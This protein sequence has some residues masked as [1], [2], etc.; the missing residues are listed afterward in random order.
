MLDKNLS[1]NVLLIGIKK[2]TDNREDQ[3]CIVPED[4]GY[5]LSRFENIIAQAQELQ[6]T[7]EERFLYFPEQWKI[8]CLREALEL[9][10]RQDDEQRNLISFCSLPV[11]VNE[12]F[13]SVVLQIKRDIYSSYYHLTVDKYIDEK[14]A[15]SLIDAT[16][17]ECLEIYTQALNK[18]NPGIGCEISAPPIYEIIRAAGRRLMY[19]PTIAC[20]GSPGW[21]YQLYDACNAISAM[22]YEGSIGKGKILLA[23]K[24]HANIKVSIPLSEPVEIDNYRSIRKL[25]EICSDNLNLLCDSDYIYGFGTTK[26]EYDLSKENLFSIKFLAQFS[27][28]LF[29]D[30]HSLMR[31]VNGQPELPKMRIEKSKFETDVSAVFPKLK[32]AD[33]KRL[34]KLVEAAIEQKHGTMVVISSKAESEAQRLKNQATVI[35]PIKLIPQV[36]KAV[37]S[38]DG[39]VLIDPKATCFAIG[40]ILDGTATQKGNPARGARYNS[41]IRYVDKEPESMAVVISEDGMVDLVSIQQK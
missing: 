36:M 33:L 32:S 29:H 34:W 28:E 35:K 15:I 25:L 19:T 12:Y 16:V 30:K 14:V 23:E 2:D 10:I 7:G 27:W 17:Q 40:V 6:F 11:L 8:R 5:D 37:T 1:S 9:L 41:A 22:K 21:Y 31:V 4:S 24:E 26:G 13:V 18:C 20:D 39:A 38:I 3:T